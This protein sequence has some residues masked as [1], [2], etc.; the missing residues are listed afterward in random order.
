MQR[1]EISKDQNKRFVY[2]TI[3]M[4]QAHLMNNLLII[5]LLNIYHDTVL[6]IVYVHAYSS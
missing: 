5:N 2:K 4:L 3:E 1:I 6:K